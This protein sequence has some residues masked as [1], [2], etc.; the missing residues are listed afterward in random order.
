MAFVSC[1]TCTYI[2]LD[3][4]GY[5]VVTGNESASV[6]AIDSSGDFQLE[7]SRGGGRI[8]GGKASRSGGVYVNG[9]RFTICNV[10]TILGQCCM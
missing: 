7:D 4:N 2:T 1:E 6:I 8:T 10:R 9:G 5:T 3:L